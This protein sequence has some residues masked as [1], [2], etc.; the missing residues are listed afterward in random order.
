MIDLGTDPDDDRGF[1]ELISRLTAGA[2]VTHR[3]F[4][5]LIYKINNWF[6]H[7]WLGFSGKTLGALGVWA[8]PLTLPPFVS[9]RVIRGWYYQ[10]DEVGGG[11]SEKASPP[12]VHHKGW[13]AQN[14]HRRC[15]EIVPASA[16]LWFSGNSATNG[17][18][19]LMAY[20]PVAYQELWPWYIAFT[21]DGEWK[22]AHRK[23]I[24][25]YEIRSFERA[26]ESPQ[27]G[28]R[29]ETGGIGQRDVFGS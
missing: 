5:L 7:K 17:R 27:Q 28:R 9:N 12:D 18:G 20:I 10:R 23:G 21:R 15:E 3:P 25:P 22:K 26:V 19:S 13:S 16:L 24:H 14:L 4:D 8:W 29:S 11:Y 2:A 1:I 6:D